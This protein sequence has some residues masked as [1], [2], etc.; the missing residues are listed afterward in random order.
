[1][2]MSGEKKAQVLELIPPSELVFKGSLP[3]GWALIKVTVP[4][5]LILFRHCI[6]CCE[7]RVIFRVATKPVN[8]PAFLA[9]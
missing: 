4:L 6:P 2:K 3:D 8:F 7:L 5:G 9:N 1:M